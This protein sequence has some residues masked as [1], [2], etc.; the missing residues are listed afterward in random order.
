[1]PDWSRTPHLISGINNHQEPFC[2]CK[3]LLKESKGTI[4]NDVLYV[5]GLLLNIVGIVSPF[6]W[7]PQLD[8]FDGVEKPSQLASRLGLHCRP[9][10]KYSQ[11]WWQTLVGERR[12][13]GPRVIQKYRE[14]VLL[15]QKRTSGIAYGEWES[16]SGET[17]SL[18][19]S[20][21]ESRIAA[22]ALE[23]RFCMTGGGAW[24]G[25]PGLPERMSLS[26]YLPAPPC[27]SSCG[28]SAMTSR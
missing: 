14:S 9:S 24:A 21:V 25:F 4:Y 27:L 7:A 16:L 5:D 8:E 1:M 15:Y 17:D 26:V 19:I 20:N 3:C 22:M 13:D 6:C 18:E 10:S 12:G 28:D 11:P 23:R 2:A